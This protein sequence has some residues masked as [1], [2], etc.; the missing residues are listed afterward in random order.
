MNRLIFQLALL[1]LFV[2]SCTEEALQIDTATTNTTVGNLSNVASKEGGCFNYSDF[3]FRRNDLMTVKSDR[4]KIFLEYDVVP[5]PGFPL[6]YNAQTADEDQV[7]SYRLLVSYDTQGNREDYFMVVFEA[8]DSRTGESQAGS[9]NL[10]TIPSSFSGEVVIYTTASEFVE[11]YTVK[12][13]KVEHRYG[14]EGSSSCEKKVQLRDPDPTDCI[15]L[16]YQNITYETVQVYTDW[17]QITSV[18]DQVSIIPLGTTVS[19]ETFPSVFMETFTY[20]PDENNYQYIPF[21]DDGGIDP[22]F[23]AYRDCMEEAQS[24]IEQGADDPCSPGLSG[25]FI[26]SALGGSWVNCLNVNELVSSLTDA[27]ND[28]VPEGTTLLEFTAET[29]A[30]FFNL[31]NEVVCEFLINAGL[32]A[33]VRTHGNFSDDQKRTISRAHNKIRENID[34]AIDIL[35]GHSGHT[36]TPVGLALEQLFGGET[37]PEFADYLANLLAYIDKF[38]IGNYRVV[39][40]E[41]LCKD[42]NL[43]VH[44][45]EMGSGRMPSMQVFICDGFFG[46]FG[47]ARNYDLME[48]YMEFY[49]QFEQEP[50]LGFEI[51][52]G[53]DAYDHIHAATLVDLIDRICN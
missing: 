33:D 19:Y 28:N 9:V 45:F 5:G 8:V 43:T 41:S 35:R 4:G 50:P 1:S 29:L 25:P 21:G 30:E 32:I 39:I 47:S 14:T 13:G 49:T 46:P 15:T 7:A 16:Y 12:N 20:C 22:F 52:D 42:P 38:Y 18:G 34:C 17:I 2:S 26:L 51:V 53:P 31:S 11:A 6:F 36:F 44:H 40:T 37:S 48:V 23:E 3:E 10:K 27:I 24:F